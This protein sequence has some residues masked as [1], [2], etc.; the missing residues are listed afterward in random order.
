MDKHENHREEE[1]EEE[2]DEESLDGVNEQTERNNAMDEAVAVKPQS[3]TANKT[4]TG[5]L[6]CGGTAVIKRVLCP[7]PESLVPD[8]IVDEMHDTALFDPEDEEDEAGLDTPTEASDL[9]NMQRRIWV[10]TTAAL[11]WR[12]GT[13]VNPLLR[14]LYLTRG[15]PKHYVTLVVPWMDDEQSRIKLYGPTNSFSQG[16]QAEQEAWIRNF[17]R[18]RANCEG[19]EE[20]VGTPCVFDARSR[21]PQVPCRGGSVASNH[22]LSRCISRSFW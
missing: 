14:A 13:A 21:S 4:F 9:R 15:R 16:G 5:R 6:D 20:A 10:V 18:E 11:P 2:K 3:T 22:V 17:C 12:T 8:E 19:K 7:D 1:E